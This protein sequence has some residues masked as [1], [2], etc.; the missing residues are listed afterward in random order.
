[1]A[2]W[3]AGGGEGLHLGVVALDRNEEIRAVVLVVLQQGFLT[4]VQGVEHEQRAVQRPEFFQ[5]GAL[6]GDLVAHFRDGVQHATGGL[7]LGAD[8]L[9]LLLVAHMRG[10]APVSLSVDGDLVVAGRMSG[11]LEVPADEHAPEC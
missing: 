1:M 2:V 9:G 11:T 5:K 8:Q 4:A 3:Q 6:G 7:A 10:A